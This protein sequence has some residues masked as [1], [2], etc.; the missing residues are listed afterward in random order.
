MDKRYYFDPS[1]EGFEAA[2]KW[3]LTMP[4][5]TGVQENM[6]VWVNAISHESYEIIMNI[7]NEYSKYVKNLNESN[8]EL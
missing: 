1:P 6:W 5:P 2:R 3:S 4:S 8:F 7:N